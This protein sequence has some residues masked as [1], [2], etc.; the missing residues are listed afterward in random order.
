MSLTNR[1]YVTKSGAVLSYKQ[2][3]TLTANAFGRESFPY[4]RE[5]AKK[6]AKEVR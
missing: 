1:G 6:S 2:R 3:L 4:G 5:C